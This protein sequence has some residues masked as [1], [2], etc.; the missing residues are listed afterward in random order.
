MMT[1][2]IRTARATRTDPDKIRAVVSVVRAIGSAIAK[3]KEQ[4][5]VEAVDEGCKLRFRFTANTGDSR[6]IVG[7]DAR[8]FIALREVARCACRGQRLRRHVEFDRVVSARAP[9]TKYVEF[10]ASDSFNPDSAVR[11]LEQILT[12]T[13]PG[14]TWTVFVADN[15]AESVRMT[16]KL[17]SGICKIDDDEFESKLNKLTKAVRILFV[18][19]GIQMGKVIYACLKRSDGSGDEADRASRGTAR[20][21]YVPGPEQDERE[22]EV[23]GEHSGQLGARSVHVHRLGNQ[24]ATG[25]AQVGATRRAT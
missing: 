24:E 6:R 15:D 21:L 5:I 8:T 25:A 1:E 2:A 13:F 7:K 16:A 10:S 12:T 14:V 17:E 19:I 22:P 3:E 4:F 18:P 11:I 20:P 9:E 23:P